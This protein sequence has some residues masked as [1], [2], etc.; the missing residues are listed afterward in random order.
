M[1][2]ESHE[3]IG[4]YVSLTVFTQQNLV[5]G[6]WWRYFRTLENSVS[7]CKYNHWS[8]LE[9]RWHEL[10]VTT[11]NDYCYSIYLCWHTSYI[12]GHILSS[13]IFTRCLNSCQLYL[14]WECLQCALEEM[15]IHLFFIRCNLWPCVAITCQ[16]WSAVS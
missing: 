9:K 8:N 13:A 10:K 5:V 2:I 7:K 15:A 12:I 1:W 3:P 6:V 14:I 4:W 16:I 11:Y